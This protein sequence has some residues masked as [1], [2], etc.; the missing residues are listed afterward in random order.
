MGFSGTVEPKR[1]RV[2]GLHLLHE[3]MPIFGS[4]EAQAPI[5]TKRSSLARNNTF[6]TYL[7]GAAAAKAH[8]S[9]LQELRSYLSKDSRMKA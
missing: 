3:G 5:E 4:F 8:G 7:K 2:L 6:A 1:P 9:T